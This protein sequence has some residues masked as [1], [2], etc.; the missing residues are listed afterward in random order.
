MTKKQRRQLSV[1]WSVALVL[2]LSALAA[3]AGVSSAIAADDPT[4]AASSSADPSPTA[5]P[6][7]G[8][9]G[10]AKADPTDIPPVETTEPTATATP[11]PCPLCPPDNYVPPNGTKFNHP[12]TPSSASDIRV[13]VRRTV[14]SVPS[15]G[16]IRLAEFSLNDDRLTDALIRA[17]N[18][19]VSVQVVANNH[20]LLPTIKALPPSK[21]FKRLRAVLGHRR[22]VTGMDPERVSFA[23]ICSLSC[24]GHGGNVHYKMF[25]FS[26]AGLGSYD[27]VTGQEIAGGRHWITM[28]GSPNLTT[29]AAYGQWNHLD[30]YANQDTYNGYMRWFKQM[31]ADKPLAHPYERINT[32]GIT[33]WTFPKPGTTAATDPWMQGLNGIRCKGANGGTGVHGRTRI[34]I[35]AYTFYDNRGRWMSKKVRSLWNAGCDIAIEYAIMGD[36]VKRT[37]YSPS[38]RGRIPMRQVVTFT[39]K[40]AINSY[41]HAKY[42]TVSGVY[43]SDHS[44]YIT[45]TGTTNISDLGFRSDDTQQVWR[46]KGRYDA[47]SRDFYQLWRQKH[48]H[49]PS[50]TS[51][52]NKRIGSPGLRLGQG[53]YAA[54]EPN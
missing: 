31:R 1:G 16:I 14:D 24:R 49:V 12:F 18:R 29:K 25:L 27:P 41:D 22:Y 50:P 6:D 33:S 36:T 52:L 44:A 2:V 51:K 47:Y 46:T 17:R 11:T 5:T 23:R 34:R 15:G 35:G 39:K 38:G 8:A 45:W 20:N 54:M 13:H 10:A 48:A 4:P 32:G 28:M 3:G 9:T 30:T 53:R 40:G 26:S 37:L 7:S 21:S 43:G 19:G 42:I